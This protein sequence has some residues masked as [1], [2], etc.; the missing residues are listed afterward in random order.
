M[1][2]NV[3]IKR[4]HNIDNKTRR[5]FLEFFIEKVRKGHQTPIFRSSITF[6]LKDGITIF[7]GTP[8]FL[9]NRRSHL[10]HDSFSGFLSS[11]STSQH[12]CTSHH[13]R[14]N[15]TWTKKPPMAS[16]A[17]TTIT[18]TT[19]LPET[20]TRIAIQS[21]R[22]M[23]ASDKKSLNPSK[24]IIANALTNATSPTM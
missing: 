5:R 14:P 9:E 8:I 10:H 12:R 20:E 13:R 21:G 3:G 1:T 17:I 6:I 18:A 22:T 2:S 4:S 11:I 7:P 24:N 19:A 23:I 15:L 16:A